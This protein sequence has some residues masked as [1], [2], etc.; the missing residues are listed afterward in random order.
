MFA[1]ALEEYVDLELAWLQRLYETRAAA[2]PAAISLPLLAD[3]FA[4]NREVG[5]PT[6]CPPTLCLHPSRAGVDQCSS[7]HL[8]F[9]QCNN[10][11]RGA[12]PLTLTR[13]QQQVGSVVRLASAW[14]SCLPH[15]VPAGGGAQR[16]GVPRGAAPCGGAAALPLLHRGPCLHRLPPRAGGRLPRPVSVEAHSG[17]ITTDSHGHLSVM[18]LCIMVMWRGRPGSKS[19]AHIPLCTCHLP[20]PKG[21]PVRTPQVATHVIGALA[22]AVE[23]ARQA[24]AKPFRPAADMRGPAL[25]NKAAYP[26]AAEG[27]G[28]VLSAVTAAASG[29][30]VRRSKLSVGAGAIAHPESA[31]SCIINVMSPISFAALRYA[32][33]PANPAHILRLVKASIAWPRQRASGLVQLLQQHYRSVVEPAVEVSPQDS[34]SCATGLTALT[35]AGEDRVTAALAAALSYLASQVRRCC[36]T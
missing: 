18:L 31:A 15:D 34:G 10:L 8:P 13:Q 6:R 29:I 21:V 11:E 4:W 23:A 30:R 3:F 20:V 19:L 28:K 12:R 25:L 27:V 33:C 17:A 7:P 24:A 14:P 32:S 36:G 1:E 16:G 35:R 5:A 26:V 2:A 9:M 22:A